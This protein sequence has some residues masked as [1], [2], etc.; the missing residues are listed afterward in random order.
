M[1]AP[2]PFVQF[3]GAEIGYP[4]RTVLAG[5]DVTLAEG[6][7]LGIVGPNGAGKTTLLRTLLGILPVRGGTRLAPRPTPPRFGYVPQRAA[8]DAIFPFTVREVVT[9][10][11]FARAG[12]LAPFGKADRDK[13]AWA[14]ERA[15]IGQHAERA[16]REL[17]GGQRQRALIARAL[18]S[19]PEILVLDE[20]TAGMDLRGAAQLMELVT[21][22][23]REGHLTAVL[24]THA[25]AEVANCATSIAIVEHG[26][27]VVG[28]VE[29]V[30][31][32]QA[33]SQMY[34]MRVEVTTVA[35]QRVIVPVPATAEAVPGDDEEHD[36]V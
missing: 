7:F 32:G 18:A 6:D 12:V 21:D 1:S 14:M 15:G 25:L 11:R 13:V 2:A 5:V 22:L 36:G 3:V 34:H 31:S 17:S 19:E 33:L 23:H 28:P 27:A 9:M 8:L 10:G 35:G 4:G 26:K 20:P 29:Q 30:L 24:V 16:Y